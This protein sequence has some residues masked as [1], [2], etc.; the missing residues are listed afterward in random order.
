MV[1][2]SVTRSAINSVYGDLV[3]GIKPH[4]NLYVCE[5]NHVSKLPPHTDMHKRPQFSLVN[6][7]NLYFFL[8][9]C[10]FQAFFA[11]IHIFK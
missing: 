8:Q 6:Q 1:K 2:K 7:Q 5:N 9:T 3:Y 11:L 4:E 10:I